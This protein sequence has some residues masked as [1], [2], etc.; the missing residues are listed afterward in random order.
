MRKREA[1]NES[2]GVIIALNRDVHA[3]DVLPEI[4]AAG[5]LEPRALNS[6]GMVTGRVALRS[7]F[8]P[9]VATLEELAF[10]GVVAQSQEVHGA[11]SL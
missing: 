6:L 3:S 5:V 9:V 7:E 8:E 10:V 2:L 11:G 4:E 1:E